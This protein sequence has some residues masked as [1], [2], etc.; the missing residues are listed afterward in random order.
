MEP[1]HRAPR[2]LVHCHRV[3]PVDS[4]LSDPGCKFLCK[5][6]QEEKESEFA[7]VLSDVAGCRARVKISASGKG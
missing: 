1:L 2:T 6:E 3:V 4:V 5:D 7:S